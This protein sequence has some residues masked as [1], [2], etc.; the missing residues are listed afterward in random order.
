MARIRV[1]WDAVASE[2]VRQSGSIEVQVAEVYGG[3]P[4]GDWP[5]IAPLA[6]RAVA[7]DVFGQRIGRLVAIRAR[8]ITTLGMRSPWRQITHLVSGRRAPIIWRRATAPTG[9]GEQN[10]DEWLDSDDGNRRYVREAGAWVAVPGGTGSLAGG[11]ATEVISTEVASVTVTRDVPP[12][13]GIFWPNYYDLASASYTNASSE[14]QTVEVSV[15]VGA[16]RTAGTADTWVGAQAS[17]SALPSIETDADRIAGFASVNA[18]L[19]RRAYMQVFSV[20]PGQTLSAR[21]VALIAVPAVLT[22]VRGRECTV[23]ITVIKR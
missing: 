10:G 19:Q 7:A 5:T 11:A 23:R 20:A 15:D 12:G 18:G 16:L 13:P 8:T 22:S 4:T 14:T 21:G 9:E 1:T 3:L 17:L 2:A 6:G